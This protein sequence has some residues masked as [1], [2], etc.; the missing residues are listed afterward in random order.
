MED[1]AFQPGTLADVIEDRAASCLTR[2]QRAHAMRQNQHEH[3]LFGIIQHQRLENIR[4]K[5]CPP[6]IDVATEKA[7]AAKA[8]G[9]SA[10][11][12]IAGTMAG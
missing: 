4:E 9:S 11:A 6:I 7:F 12:S 3:T 5:N 2:R 8:A 1:V 10:A